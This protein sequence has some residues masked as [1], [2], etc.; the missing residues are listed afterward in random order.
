[1][2]EMRHS[3]MKEQLK[4]VFTYTACSS[5]MKEEPPVK[6]EVLDT[7]YGRDDATYVEYNHLEI[8]EEEKCYVLYGQLL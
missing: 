1:M 7:L 6:L 5:Y 2:S 4:K 3:F 8:L